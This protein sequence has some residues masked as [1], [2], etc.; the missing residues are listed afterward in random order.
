MVTQLVRRVQKRAALTYAHRILARTTRG[1]TC[2]CV[3]DAAIPVPP[4]LRRALLD[5]AELTGHQRLSLLRAAA[6]C[7]TASSWGYTNRTGVVLDT[8]ARRFFCAVVGT[9]AP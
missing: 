6:A 1:R 2:D 8:S 7:S 5:S 9:P 4:R 3:I